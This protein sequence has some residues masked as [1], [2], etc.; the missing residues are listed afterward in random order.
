MYRISP[1]LSFKSSNK[2]QSKV[3]KKMHNLSV[4]V[5]RTIIERMPTSIRLLQLTGRERES[6]RE[7]VLILN[8]GL[9]TKRTTWRDRLYPVNSGTS[10]VVTTLS[11][12]QQ[13][14]TWLIGS[15]CKYFCYR[16]HISSEYNQR[17]T[18]HQTCTESLAVRP[19]SKN[20]SEPQL[21]IK[22]LVIRWQRQTY[23]INSWSY[24]NGAAFG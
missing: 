20:S 19:P 13:R 15:K 9:W 8:T 21:I 11:T 18:G 6:M 3:A 23:F 24:T 7:C 12:S 2:V 17:R 4:N 14:W 22:T 1:A 10:S 5:Q 16:A